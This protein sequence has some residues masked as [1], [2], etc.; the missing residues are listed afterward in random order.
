MRFGV[1][2]WGVPG[3]GFRDR[4][5]LLDGS[6]VVAPLVL[7]LHLPRVWG[8]EFGFGIR[9]SRFGRTPLILAPIERERECV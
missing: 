2:D 3:F 8:L 7:A 1:W 5:Y 9:V 6:G 4:V